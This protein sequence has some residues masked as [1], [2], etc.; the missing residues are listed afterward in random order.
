MREDLNCVKTD[1]R[2]LNDSV[3]RVCDTVEEDED[4]MTPEPMEDH[5]T[6]ELMDPNEYLKENLTNQTSSNDNQTCMW[7]YRKL[8]MCSLSGYDRPQRYLSIWLE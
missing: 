1:L 3:N 5:M 7:K 2:S 4:H 8:E 6:P